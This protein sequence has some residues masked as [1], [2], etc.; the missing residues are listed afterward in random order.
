MSNLESHNE[1]P[2]ENSSRELTEAQLDLMVGGSG[3][4]GSLWTPFHKGFE[5]YSKLFA[6][7]VQPYYPPLR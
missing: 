4:E 2:E 1:L 5:Q 3:T 7:S 6:P